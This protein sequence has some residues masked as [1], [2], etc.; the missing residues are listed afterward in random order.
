MNE[1]AKR[2][3]NLTSTGYEMLL[4]FAARHDMLRRF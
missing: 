3:K 4:R 1:D 2:P